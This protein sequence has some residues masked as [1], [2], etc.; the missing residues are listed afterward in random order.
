[1][2]HQKKRHVYQRLFCIPATPLAVKERGWCTIDGVLIVDL[3]QTPELSDR[4]TALSFES[5]GLPDRVLVVHGIDGTYYAYSN[6]CA[7]G[8][9]RVDPVP[10]E[11][12]IRCCTLM[13]STY[14]YNGKFL[15]GSANKDLISYEV[16]KTGDELR[17]QVV[18]GGRL[19]V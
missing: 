17:V 5:G 8:G 16:S 7:C 14:D 2:S 18:P 4:D 9:F 6:H 19:A 15:K 11:Q 1:M 12:K 10:G 13:Q 3:S